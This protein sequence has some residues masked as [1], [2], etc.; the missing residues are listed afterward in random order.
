MKKLD[1]LQHNSAQE[2]KNHNLEMERCKL[3]ENI[4]EYNTGNCHKAE[5]LDNFG[6]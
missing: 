6:K 2:Y 3:V 1:E 5:R 4:K